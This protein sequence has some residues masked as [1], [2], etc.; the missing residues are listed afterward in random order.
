M[1]DEEKK[2]RKKIQMREYMNKRRK[3]DPVFAEKL[4]ENCRVYNKKNPNK[5]CYDEETRKKYNTEYYLNKKNKL[6]RKMKSVK[7]MLS[8]KMRTCKQL[9]K[10][11]KQL[12]HKYKK[13]KKLSK[14]DKKDKKLSKKR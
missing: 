12:S 8:V 6:K 5:A 2:E 7:K 1:T 3:E 11:Y 13:Y 9:S 14:R 4:R 10:K